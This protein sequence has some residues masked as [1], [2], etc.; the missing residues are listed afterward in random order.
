M[1][2]TVFSPIS[3][4]LTFALFG[5]VL[6]GVTIFGFNKIPSKKILLSCNA[7]KTAPSTLYVTT[8]HL[9]IECD[10]SDKISG[11]TIGTKPFS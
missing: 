7:L 6:P 9:S 8:R 11:S 5:S 1:A 10:P 3:L 2:I 4:A